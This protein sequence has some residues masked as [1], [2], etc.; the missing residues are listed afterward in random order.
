MRAE[1][2]AGDKW[3]KSIQMTHCTR[4]FGKKTGCLRIAAF[5][6]GHDASMGMIVSYQG[7]PV[8]V[9][10][11][12]WKKSGTGFC[13]RCKATLQ[14]TSPYFSMARKPKWKDQN[15]K[16]LWMSRN[17]LLTRNPKFDWLVNLVSYAPTMCRWTQS[18]TS[19]FSQSWLGPCRTYIYIYIAQEIRERPQT[20]TMHESFKR[21]ELW[22]T[23]N[24]VNVMAR[25]SGRTCHPKLGNA[26][27]KTKSWIQH[28]LGELGLHTIAYCYSN[29]L[30]YRKGARGLLAIFDR[31]ALLAVIEEL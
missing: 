29:T 26:W 23:G 20:P 30:F 10:R 6:F 15:L 22:V 5:G 21:T 18:V 16:T 4:H 19:N 24:K 14:T 13:R 31:P 7:A 8:V 3:S 17:G 25:R 27:S 11:L 9:R 1:V 2:W 28:L 12:Q